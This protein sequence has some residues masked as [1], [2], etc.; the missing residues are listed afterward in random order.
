MHNSL[1]KKRTYVLSR[2]TL[3]TQHENMEQVAVIQRQLSYELMSNVSQR[4]YWG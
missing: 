2:L 4:E 3:D 1:G